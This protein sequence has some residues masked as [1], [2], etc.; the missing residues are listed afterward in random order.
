MRLPNR[1]RRSQPSS[2]H[3]RLRRQRG[4]LRARVPP[5]ARAPHLR[6]F[7][8]PSAHPLGS[9]PPRPPLGPPRS[10]LHPRTLRPHGPRAPRPRG[11]R[12][13]LREPHPWL[14]RPLERPR[15]F[16]R[17][18][19]SLRARRHVRLQVRPLLLLDVRP[20]VRSPRPILR[21]LP[22]SPTP[23]HHREHRDLR[24]AQQQRSLL[25][26]PEPRDFLQRQRCPDG[27]PCLPYRRSRALDRTSPSLPVP[28]RTRL[29]KPLRHAQEARPTRRPA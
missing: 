27:L 3:Q 2:Q 23:V 19:G 13:S 24:R 14:P 5:E 8:L 16:D 1:L 21:A 29:A 17:R 20:R 10:H 7:E 15:P 25:V 4:R 22:P 11:P 9:L 6:R 18:Q 26:H 12:C 28:F